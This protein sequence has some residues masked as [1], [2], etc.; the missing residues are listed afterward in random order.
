MNF[1]NELHLYVIDKQSQTKVVNILFSIIL[2]ANKKNNYNILLPISNS[3]GSIIIQRKWLIN[4]MKKLRNLFISDYDSDILDC[5]ET[6]TIKLLNQQEISKAING[7]ILYKK[8][9]EL[10]DK[11]IIDLRNVN[12]SLYKSYIK[13]FKI[14]SN[15]EKQTIEIEKN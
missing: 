4:E 5:K 13:E 11:I 6:I 15:T 8:A 1:P 2:N 12:N 14:D 9:L 3:D 7:I 10:T